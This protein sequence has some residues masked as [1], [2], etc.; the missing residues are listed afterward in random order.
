M[1]GN[2]AEGIEFV[3]GLITRYAVVEKLYLHQQSDS[4]PRL[5]EAVSK[6]YANV[7]IYL[8]KVK[9]YYMG[10]TWS[11]CSIT[12]VLRVYHSTSNTN[13]ELIKAQKGLLEA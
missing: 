11:T 3:A 6:L 12:V 9:A 7:L 8:S 5:H 13:R 10:N 4:T 1:F 2:V